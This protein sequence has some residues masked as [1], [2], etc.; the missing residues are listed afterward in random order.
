MTRPPRPWSP[1][2]WLGILCCLMLLLTATLPVMAAA[3]ASA[4][5]APHAAAAHSAQNC[6]TAPSGD[7][8]YVPP[9]PLP[10]GPHGGIIW[11]RPSAISATT[12]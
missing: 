3:S 1:I 12:C 7:A 5:P 11:C 8:F 9:K 10:R 4:A 2:P 6:H